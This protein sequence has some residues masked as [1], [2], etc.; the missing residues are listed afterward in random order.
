M[1]L[2]CCAKA[3]LMR[4][5]KG[6]LARTAAVVLKRHRLRLGRWLPFAR[7]VHGFVSMPDVAD[8][9]SVRIL[10][11]V[12]AAQLEVT[13]E[14]LRGFY[15]LSFAHAEGATFIDEGSA[16]VVLVHLRIAGS[17]LDESPRFGNAR[18]NYGGLLG[19][20]D[21]LAASG[22][23]H[24]RASMDGQQCGTDASLRQAV[25]SA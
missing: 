23:D 20:N 2:Q 16:P 17:A 11:V 3:V 15:S 6:N 1:K 14:T 10:V 4:H 8:E 18:W 12:E 24:Q 9:A 19:D 22:D 13:T 7:I 5:D 25:A 21:R